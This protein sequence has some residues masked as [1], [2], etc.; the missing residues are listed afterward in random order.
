MSKLNKGY[1]GTPLTSFSLGYGEYNESQ[2]NAVIFDE[3]TR[4]I[5]HF[6]L[7]NLKLKSSTLVSN[8][9]AQHFLFYY[10][11][12]D[13]IFDLS[14]GNLSILNS[15]RTTVNHQ[16]KFNG[17]PLSVAVQ[18][19][20][21]LFV[22]YDDLN[23]TG[24]VKMATTGTVEKSWVGGPLL[25]TDASII[26]GD[27]NSNGQ[28]VLSLTG[29]TIAIVDVAQTLDQQQWVFEQFGTGISNINWMTQLPNQPEF[30]LAESDSQIVLI[31][32]SVKAIV[33]S[34][35]ISVMDIQQ[36]SKNKNPHV[37]LLDQG[38]LKIAAVQ[39]NNLSLITIPQ[40]ITKILYSD[41]NLTEGVWTFVETNENLSEAVQNS[42]LNNIDS[43]KTSRTLKQIRLS[44]M[45]VIQ[46][47]SLNDNTQVR[48]FADNLFTLYPSP[49]GYVSKYNFKSAESVELKFFNLSFFNR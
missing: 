17:W 30:F 35:N 13:F 24:I 36:V 21:G 12:G 14:I 48:M 49:M 5:H 7:Q 15:E 42:R 25:A 37:I 28:L 19:Q 31:N 8:P 23:T 26:A 1:I 41:L 27:L 38:V 43:T 47:I 32:L 40:T 45:L 10:N 16:L 3:T 2:V 34:I 20:L 39:S 4:R 6:D 29:G 18:E 33:D 22:L 46:S 11:L 9:E 44:D